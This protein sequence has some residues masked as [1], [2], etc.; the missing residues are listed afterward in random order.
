MPVLQSQLVQFLGGRS[1]TSPNVPSG[2]TQTSPV[3]GQMPIA[4]Q[5]YV[6]ALPPSLFGKIL[7]ITSKLIICIVGTGATIT[8]I[9]VVVK[10]CRK[11]KNI[12]NKMSEFIDKV[13]PDLPLYKKMAQR[14]ND[15]IQE[16][17]PSFL[18]D[19]IKRDICGVT[20][21]EKLTAIIGRDYTTNHS[22]KKLN[23]AGLSLLEDSKM[24]RFVEFYLEELIAKLEELNPDN[25]LDVEQRSLTVIWDKIKEDERH[26]AIFKNY[27]FNH[28]DKTLDNLFL[29][30]SIY[31]R[32]KFFDKHPELLNEKS[33][34]QWADQD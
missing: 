28:P 1:T 34:E 5:Q 11:L 27:V 25:T 19:L 8:S 29:V 10:Y 2:S 21:I 30:G 24:K 3:S 20:P 31:L 17:F 32:D 7:D 6:L 23:S 18:Q 16:V 15:V 26:L 9:W 4:P 14:T 12:L 33:G 22:P 13:S